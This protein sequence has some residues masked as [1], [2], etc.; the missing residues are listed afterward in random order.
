MVNFASIRPGCGAQCLGK[1]QLD[2]TV[3]VFRRFNNIY[4]QLA[5][6]VKEST[7]DNVEVGPPVIS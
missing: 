4:S 6:Y 3:K 2:V 7:C 5:F 1:H